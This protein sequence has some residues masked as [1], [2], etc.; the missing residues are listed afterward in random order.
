MEEGFPQGGD[1][2]PCSCFVVS[3]HG[4]GWGCVLCCVFVLLIVGFLVGG[5]GNGI[6]HTSVYG[7]LCRGRGISISEGEKINMR[8]KD[9]HVHLTAATC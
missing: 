5:G 4:G 7:I 3:R 9:P 8:G 6:F 2:S 1:D